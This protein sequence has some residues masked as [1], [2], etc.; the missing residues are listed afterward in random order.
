MPDTKNVIA[1]IKCAIGDCFIRETNESI[2]I[3][4]LIVRK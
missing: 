1:N 3:V 4:L 2:I